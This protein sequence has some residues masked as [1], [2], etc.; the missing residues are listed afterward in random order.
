MNNNL[1]EAK[2]LD[3]DTAVTLN[4]FD[5]SVSDTG[6][7]PDVVLKKR[8]GIK[9]QQYLVA[10]SKYKYRCFELEVENITGK[11]DKITPSMLKVPSYTEKLFEGSYIQNIDASVA[12]YIFTKIIGFCD[13]FSALVIILRDNRSAIVDIIKYRPTRDGY[14]NLP[15]YLYEKSENKPLRRGDDFL[16]P[17]QI[18]M[19]RLIEKES[20]AFLGEGLKNSVNS[21][22]RSIPFV[23]IEGVSNASSKGIAEYINGLFHRGIRIYGAM[24]GDSAGEKAFNEINKLLDNPIKNIID[25]DS[26]LDFTDY[27]RKEQL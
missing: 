15:K 7:L 27:L 9:A 4:S 24:D 14:E 21:L 25:F 17:F 22:I 13:Y 16:Y 12:K 8:L 5:K 2:K 18:E 10:G 23:S 11:I 3:F 26:G 1:P 20:Y 19:G 6:R